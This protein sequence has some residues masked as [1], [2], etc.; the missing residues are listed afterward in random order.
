MLIQNVGVTVIYIY[1]TRSPEPGALAREPV[2][3]TSPGARGPGLH[4]PQIDDIQLKKLRASSY[5]HHT[6]PIGNILENH[7]ISRKR[8][9][10]Q[11]LTLGS[12]FGFLDMRE[13]LLQTF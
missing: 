2:Y 9:C 10:F 7:D 12:I 5:P 8:Y 3:I 11:Y 6:G 13:T 4:M 1:I